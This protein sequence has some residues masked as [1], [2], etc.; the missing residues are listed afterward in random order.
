M[1]QGNEEFVMI[2]DQKIVFEAAL[3]LSP[4]ASSKNKKVLIVKGGPGTGKSVVAVNLLVELTKRG[5]VTQ[6]ISKN[7]A[8]RA[9][10]ESKLTIPVFYTQLF[11][12]NT[13]S[14]QIIN[15]HSLTNKTC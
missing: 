13:L 15:A 3:A 5:L 6:Y 1:L 7:A 10:Y 14:S 11:Y 4:I 9:V 8:S 12:I 2:D